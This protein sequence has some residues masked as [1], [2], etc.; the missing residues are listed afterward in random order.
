MKAIKGSY[1]ATTIFLMRPTWPLSNQAFMTC[2]EGMFW[3]LYN[4]TLAKS[5]TNMPQV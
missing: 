5:N 2:L 4:P 3:S 1:L